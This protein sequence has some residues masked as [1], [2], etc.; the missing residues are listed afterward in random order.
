MDQADRTLKVRGSLMNLRAAED[1][2][3]SNA[4]VGEMQLKLAAYGVQDT[5]Q[6]VG[7]PKQ[8]IDYGAFRSF[9]EGGDFESRPI[10]HYLDHGDAEIRKGKP[11]SALKIGKAVGYEEREDGLVSET[12]YNLRKQV[13]RDAM[14]DILFNP[15][16]ETFSFR[17]MDEK[18]TVG[19]DRLR[20]VSWI[21]GIQEQSQVGS[22]GAQRETGV[23][24]ETIHMRSALGTHHTGV[25]DEEWDEQVQLRSLSTDAGEALFERAFAYYD[26]DAD[27]LDPKGYHFM[28][29]VVDDGRVAEANVKA[30]EAG[31]ERLNAR[32]G[33][34]SFAERRSIYRHLAGHLEEAGTP[35]TIQLRQSFPPERE[36]LTEWMAEP[37]F[38]TMAA[39]L[40][41]VKVDVQI[42]PSLV[43]ADTDADGKLEP[44]AADAY[45]SLWSVRR[46]KLGV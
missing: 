34:F 40:L 30:C 15:E 45:S 8:V 28:H 44:V 20:H 38:R 3:L 33:D 6:P 25:V 32:M 35:V 10:P 43:A 37:A 41:G 5:H 24:T 21:D 1:A 13:A 29:H 27:P 36:Q 16:G 46:R 42:N 4:T 17:W 9:I 12:H 18:E 39:E 2:F 31:I 23:L 22:L 26:P 11:T 19:S 14:S 7:V